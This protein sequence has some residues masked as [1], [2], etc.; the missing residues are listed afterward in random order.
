MCLMVAYGCSGRGVSC[1]IQLASAIDLSNTFKLTPK[2]NILGS[3]ANRAHVDMLLHAPVNRLMQSLSGFGWMDQKTGSCSAS[4]VELG[5]RMRIQCHTCV[6]L[7]TRCGT[8]DL[9]KPSQIV[10]ITYLL[11]PR[12]SNSVS[13]DDLRYL[14]DSCGQAQ[15][16]CRP[17]PF[18]RPSA[19]D[20]RPSRI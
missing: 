6:G 2:A 13:V 9:R 3:F 5:A 17:R 16:A 10:V 14:Q 1:A 15:D 7:L 11:L 18:R 4:R 12:L 20:V 19:R 8:R